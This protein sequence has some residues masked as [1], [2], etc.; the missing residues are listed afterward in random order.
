MLS[1][2]ER[3][4]AIRE[5]MSA[6]GKVSRCIVALRVANYRNVGKKAITALY[7]TTCTVYTEAAS[8][9]LLATLLTVY[10]IWRLVLL[11]T[12]PDK[13]PDPDTVSWKDRPGVL[14]KTDFLWYLSQRN[15]FK[16]GKEIVRNC[17]R[18]AMDRLRL[19]NVYKIHDP[20]V[21]KM[22]RLWTIMCADNDLQAI[23]VLRNGRVEAEEAVRDAVRTIVFIVRNRGDELVNWAIDEQWLLNREGLAPFLVDFTGRA[24]DGGSTDASF[25]N[26]TLLGP[27]IASIRATSVEDDM[28]F[29]AVTKGTKT[30]VREALYAQQGFGG[31]GFI[32]EHAVETM[33]CIDRET[34][35]FPWHSRKGGSAYIG[36]NT[37]RLFDSFGLTGDPHET[38]KALTAKVRALLPT[39]IYVGGDRIKVDIYVDEHVIQQNCCKLFQV[40]QFVLSRGC[41]GKHGRAPK[42]GR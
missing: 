36:S 7:G 20:I 33:S 8:L 27:F 14:A 17:M 42:E 24:G 38:L 29:Q 5:Y 26:S 22:G 28:L 3:A 19:H 11:H 25:S 32:A 30:Q 31:D 12:Y 23:K 9:M 16:E 2:S 18:V 10:I 34:D 13:G 37:R 21:A 35:I 39:A 41:V 15:V 40:L 1:V 4:K 6:K